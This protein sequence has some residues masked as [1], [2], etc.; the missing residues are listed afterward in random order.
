MLLQNEVCSGKLSFSKSCYSCQA[1]FSLY[2][3]EAQIMLIKSG[4]RS[5]PAF[6]A[7]GGVSPISE[8]RST[9]KHGLTQERRAQQGLLR[10]LTALCSQP[11]LPPP[12]ATV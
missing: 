3:T 1:G 4:W 5:A 9:G 10:G 8:G 12:S 11:C 6:L 2:M 7:C